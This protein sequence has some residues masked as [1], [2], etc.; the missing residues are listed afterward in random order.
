MSFDLGR[1][2]R[3]SF[4]LFFSIAKTRETPCL[5]IVQNIYVQVTFPFTPLTLFAPRLYGKYGASGYL[6]IL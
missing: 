6:G 5:Q 3:F 2:L 4:F 1:L